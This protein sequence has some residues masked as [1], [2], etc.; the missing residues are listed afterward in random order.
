[1]SDKLQ[2]RKFVVWITWLIIAVVSIIIVA[3]TVIITKEFTQYVA[4]FTE[5]VLS[6]FF[7]ISMMYLGVNVVQKGAFAIADVF[8]KKE[9]P[10]DPN[11]ED[12]PV[13]NE[14]EAER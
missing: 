13:E 8:A 7:A 6:W 9:E 3:V 4:T 11:R 12:N 1:M 14:L 2:S 5:K 10:V